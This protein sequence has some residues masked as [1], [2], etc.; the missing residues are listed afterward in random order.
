MVRQKLWAGWFVLLAPGLTFANDRFNLTLAAEEPV[1]ALNAY[2]ALSEVQIRNAMPLEN[3]T[4]AVSALGPITLTLE[5]QAASNKYWLGLD[6]DDEQ[7]SLVVLNVVEGSPAADAGL[8]VNDVVTVAKLDN[9]E[10]TLTSVEQFS[11]LV[12]SARNQPLTLTVTRDGQ[13]TIV[14]VTPTERPV[15]VVARADGSRD[16]DDSKAA[17]GDHPRK[18]RHGAARGKHG[19]RKRDGQRHARHHHR[20]LHHGFS[21]H[22]GHRHH[23]REHAFAGPHPR[24]GWGMSHGRHFGHARHFAGRHRGMGRGYGVL[25]MRHGHHRFGHQQFGFPGHSRFGSVWGGTRR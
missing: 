5:L 23:G 20:R 22:R 3:E 7:Q 10:H 15:P 19:D 2:A 9:N 24:H 25:A 4:A 13:S 8:K 14:A 11:Q 17:R 1:S 6:C 21:H 18:H 16:K 12:Q